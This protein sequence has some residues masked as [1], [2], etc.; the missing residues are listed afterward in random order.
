[1]HYAEQEYVT[2]C[3]PKIALAAGMLFLTAGEGP[4]NRLFALGRHLAQECTSCHRPDGP[5]AGGI[6]S[7][8]GRDPKYLVEALQMYKSGQRTNPTMVS[9]AQ[10]L[11]DE[12][13]EALA[14]YFASLPK[15]GGG[16][17]SAE[18]GGPT[19]QR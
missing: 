19:A 4:T 12:H 14:R 17:A 15:R 16:N 7:I 6:P 11:D 10:S 9:V 2:G 3:F 8:V 18:K 13:I 5:S 1:M